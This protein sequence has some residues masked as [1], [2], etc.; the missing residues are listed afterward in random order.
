VDRGDDLRERLVA[1]RPLALALA[2][3]FVIEI[4]LAVRTGIGFATKGPAGFEAVNDPGNA[5][6]VAKVLFRDY[7]LP[8]EV[9][10]VL[11]II[12]AIATMVLGQRKARAVTQAELEAI[13]TTGP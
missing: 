8:F 7:F 4:A 12:A 10:S 3:G 5:Q 6:A 1:Q 13:E 9:T 2:A 11:L